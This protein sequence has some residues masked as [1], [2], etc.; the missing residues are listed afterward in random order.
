MRNGS[1]CASCPRSAVGFCGA[2]LGKGVRAASG[3]SEHWQ[4]HRVVPAGRQIVGRSQS[5]PEV[6]TLCHGWGF[7]FLQ[8]A[9]GRRQILGFL[10][11]GDL[12]SAGSVFEER[13]PFS[14]RALTDVQI[15]T[16]RRTEIQSR[17][18]TN[19]AVIA[20]LTKICSAETKYSE[21]LITALGQCSAEERIAFLVLQLTERIA[22]RNVI[23]EQQYPFPLRQQHIADA[24]GLTAVH[25]SRVLGLFRERGILELSSGV[26]KIH[27]MAEV[28]RLGSLG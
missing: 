22:A 28:R 11:P 5:S 7:R 12:F 20:A 13:L 15:S 24:V 18:L 9:D 2:V 26:L 27:N 1:P 16:M 4:E 17:L 25:V 10:L 21:E 19:P 14:V 6:F 8:L 3:E 23:R